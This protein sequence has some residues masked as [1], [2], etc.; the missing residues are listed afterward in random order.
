[1]RAIILAA[2][3]GSRLHPYTENVPKC[4]TELGGISLIGRQLKTLRA[5]GIEDI[6]ILTGYQ[7]E[8]LALN[9]TRQVLNPDWSKTNMVESLFC[10]S[11]KFGNDL[12]VSYSDIV[13][14]PRILQALLRSSHDVSVV[15]DKKWRPYW[16]HRFEDPLSDAETLKLD[17]NGAITEIGNPP[18]NIEAI[19]AQYI[20]LMRFRGTGVDALKAART[21]LRNEYRPWMEKRTVENAYMTD[22]LM[23]MILLGTPVQGVP[24]ESGWLEIDTVEDFEAVTRGF[25]TGEIKRFFDPQAD[26]FNA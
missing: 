17:P 4:L 16:E 20:G 2:G 13:Y 24:V 25:E 10:A 3:R 15:V 1:M 14:E 18:D 5:C 6:I 26:A 9:N 19:E 22:L 8:L 7:A 11:G 12:I 23:E 21:N